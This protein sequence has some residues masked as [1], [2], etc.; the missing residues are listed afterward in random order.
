MK[1]SATSGWRERELRALAALQ[2]MPARDPLYRT[3]SIMS[4]F[5]FVP[6]CT[7]E[8][9]SQ[10]RPSIDLQFILYVERRCCILFRYSFIFLAKL[11]RNKMVVCQKNYRI[12]VCNLVQC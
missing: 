8:E 2:S 6:R 12:G 5:L 7:R 10:R 1:D 4:T 9:H 3:E 11:W